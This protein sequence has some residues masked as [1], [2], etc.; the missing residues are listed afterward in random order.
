M[1]RYA[2]SLEMTF[3]TCLRIPGLGR[4][5]YNN[6]WSRIWMF[7]H[8]TLEVAGEDTI[9]RVFKENI[10]VKFVS[11]NTDFLIVHK[12]GNLISTSF[13]GPRPVFLCNLLPGYSYHMCQIHWFSVKYS[14]KRCCKVRGCNDVY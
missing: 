8:L 14:S 2:Y 3:E 12:R 13:I 9:H 5:S 6:T 7:D 10:S 11:L 4:C 1:H